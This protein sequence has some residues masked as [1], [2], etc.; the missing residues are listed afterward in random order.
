[1][2]AEPLCG[3]HLLKLG[4]PFQITNVLF[5]EESRTSGVKVSAWDMRDLRE[6][7]EL[8]MDTSAS[9]LVVIVSTVNWA[10]SVVKAMVEQK[11]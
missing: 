7:L 3:H 9:I 1:M 11:L 2:G 8:N 5:T 4:G 10:S 6:R